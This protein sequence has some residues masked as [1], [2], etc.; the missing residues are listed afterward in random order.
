MGTLGGQMGKGDTASSGNLLK[1]HHYE[2]E[3]LGSD[4]AGEAGSLALD[5]VGGVHLPLA[6]VSVPR[7]SSL[8]RLGAQDWPTSRFSNHI[9]KFLP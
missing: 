9:H 8:L 5:A 2:W 6:S 3:E 4:P 1:P 7:A